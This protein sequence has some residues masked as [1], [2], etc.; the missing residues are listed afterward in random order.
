MDR[1]EK[2]RAQRIL[3]LLEESKLQYELKTYK[4]QNLLAP[5]EL[6]DIHPLGKAPIVSIET[7]GMPKPL[8]LAESGPIVE[9][10]TDHFNPGLIP[11]RYPVGKE[12]QI[13]METEEW[14][15]YRYLMHYTEG[16]L[17][18]LM[19]VKLLMGS[20]EHRGLCVTNEIANLW[21]QI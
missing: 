17:M 14:L 5:A 3:W 16:S 20:K 18:T 11:T 7:E 12:G 1:L 19:L 8:I 15:R 6:K 13:G 10:L 21:V 9:Y 4:R 2:S